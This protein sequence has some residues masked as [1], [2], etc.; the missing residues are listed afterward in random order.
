[1][2]ALVKVLS[3]VSLAALIAMPAT[4]AEQPFEKE[5]EARQA[6]MQ[7]VKYNMGI[8]GAMAKGKREYDAGLADAVAK[9]MFSAA[10]MN[11][12]SMWPP[13]SDNSVESLA[14]LTKAKPS[15]WAEDSEV[16]TK[17]DAWVQAS[18]NMAATA[19]QDLASLRKAMGPLGKS[20]KGCHKAYKTK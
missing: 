8:L 5:I 9:N 6:Q 18:E 15:M 4:A 1:M 2:T 20:C 14:E 13:G 3:A 10:T 17:H 12:M 7:V 16:G 11:N 19:G